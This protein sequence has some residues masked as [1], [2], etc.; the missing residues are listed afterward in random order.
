MGCSLPK[1]HSHLASEGKAYAGIQIYQFILDT[2][3]GQLL[4]PE[5]RGAATTDCA[6]TLPPKKLMQA[7]VDFY[8]CRIYL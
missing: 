4:A 6:R 5:E 7:K 8:T 1:A 2:Y 3:A